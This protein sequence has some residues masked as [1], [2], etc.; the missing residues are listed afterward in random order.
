MERDI[1]QRAEGGLLLTASKNRG[2]QSSS[3]QGTECCQQPYALTSEFL[4]S[5][6]SDEIAALVN[7]PIITLGDPGVEAPKKSCPDS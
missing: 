3:L 1:L 5:Q 6:A 7:K 4:S 2:P